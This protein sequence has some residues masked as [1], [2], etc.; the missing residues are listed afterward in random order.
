MS[1][2]SVVKQILIRRQDRWYDKELAGKKISYDRWIREKERNLPKTGKSPVEFVLFRQRE[3]VLAKK[4]AEHI[5]VCF[6]EHP[7]LLIL[8]GDEDLQKEERVS[9]W[10]KPDWSPDT[11]RAC[12]YP[13]SVI[14]V[15]R[16][17]L[18]KESR[19]EI[20]FSDA[21]EIRPV[22]DDLF[23]K[24]GGFEKGCRAIGHMEEILFHG[25]TEQLR[26]AYL[27]TP[28]STGLKE[29]LFSESTK[30]QRPLVSVI[31]P[32][33]DNPAVLEKCLSSLQGSKEDLEIIVVDNGSSTKNREAVER[34]AAGEGMRYVYE[35][36]EFNFSA[37]CNRGAYLARGSLLLFLNDDVEMQGADCLSDMAERAMLPYVGGVGLKLYYPDS[38]RIQHDGIVNLPIGPVHKLQYLEDDREY[39]FGRNRL[40]CN[41]VAVTGACLMLEKKKFEEAGGFCDALRV[42]Y[43]DVDL[44]FRL[45]E[46]GYYNVVFNRHYAYHHEFLS[47]GDDD[48]PEKKKRL[49]AE[50]RLLYRM[51]PDFCGKDPY[52]PW[53]LSRETLDSRI[54]PAYLTARNIKQPPAWKPFEGSMESIRRDDCLMARVETPGPERI[55]GYSVV[56][57][58][59]N[60]CYDKY[61]LLVAE[62]GDVFSMKT[63]GAYRQD[64][65]KNLPDQKNVALGG[66]CVDRQGEHLPCGNYRIAVLAVNRVS[67]L[68]L[69]ND[70]GKELAVERDGGECEKT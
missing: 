50:R 58:D 63:E 5:S 47:R 60:A 40:D 20:L 3:G 25:K 66:F 42:A 44:G 39:Y 34:L 13:G 24:A 17:L 22:M 57:G 43:N 67:R 30:K 31:I 23:Q 16:C 21:A 6:A 55:Q 68:R 61:L 2:Q 7:E 65:E 48:T 1:M 11:Y 52:Y 26:Q 36:A 64:L 14:A 38:V 12:F 9:P 10:F 19:R 51:H 56:L 53:G 15:R 28:E 18:E 8:Y 59:D 4:A 70:T 69:W 35:P 29:A 37:M 33:K 41:C 46:L 32:S 27:L 45:R 54:I 62:N 49:A